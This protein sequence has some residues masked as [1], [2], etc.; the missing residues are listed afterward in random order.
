MNAYLCVACG[1]QAA[2][3]LPPDDCDACNARRSFVD[4]ADAEPG[5]VDGDGFAQF[6]VKD[7]LVSFV[8]R[9]VVDD[10][11]EL[12]ALVAEQLVDDV[13]S[14]RPRR[15]PRRARRSNHVDAFGFDIR[16]D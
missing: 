5:T 14:S 7:E 9:V 10:G 4:V 12:R 13:M 11:D 3:D 1:A 16:K 15:S 8:P 6:E 2:G